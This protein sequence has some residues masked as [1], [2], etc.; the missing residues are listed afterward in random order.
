M[1]NKF[2]WVGMFLMVLFLGMTVVGCAMFGAMAAD[3]EAKQTDGKGGTIRVANTTTHATGHRYWVV[4]P[5]RDGTYTRATIYGV[6][7]GSV[8]P[9]TVDNDGS[10]LIYYRAARSDESSN[11]PR[12]ENYQSWN[13]KSVYV[14]NDETV[15][16]ELP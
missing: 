14:S 7:S 16:V 12:D 6:T 4:G 3:N 9:Y 15:R 8:R 10:Y 2:K 11:P 13:R 5:S 1:A